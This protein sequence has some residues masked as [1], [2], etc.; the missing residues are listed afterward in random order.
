MD[1]PLGLHNFSLLLELLPAYTGPLVIAEECGARAVYVGPEVP[2]SDRFDSEDSV[3]AEDPDTEPGAPAPAPSTFDV[4]DPQHTFRTLC[5]MLEC[6]SELDRIHAE[7]ERHVGDRDAE[8]GTQYV[9]S[10][11][12]LFVLLRVLR[13]HSTFFKVFQ[14]P[15]SGP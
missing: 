13:T 3:D 7:Y 6:I 14:G 11:L 5:S 12:E 10:S 15:D 8:L 4:E 9:A 2:G 1:G